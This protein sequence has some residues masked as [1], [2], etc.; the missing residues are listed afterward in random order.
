MKLPGS[1]ECDHGDEGFGSVEAAALVRRRLMAALSDGGDDVPESSFD[2][3]FDR[4]PVVTDRAGQLDECCLALPG[5]VI[6]PA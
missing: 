1:V 2:G 4:V 3:C 5:R 6:A